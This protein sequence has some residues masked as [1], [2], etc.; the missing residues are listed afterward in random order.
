MNKIKRLFVVSRET[1]KRPEAH[2]VLDPKVIKNGLKTGFE[3]WF[4]K[5][6][7]FSTGYR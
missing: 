6:Q 2:C 3:S 5:N 1:G 4:L 7:Q